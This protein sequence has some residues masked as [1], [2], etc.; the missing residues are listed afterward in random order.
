MKGDIE[1]KTKVITI[2]LLFSV[3]ITITIYK[4][5]NLGG[6]KEKPSPYIS[7]EQEKNASFSF[8][9]MAD[10]RGTDGG[11]NKEAII[12]TMESI[13]KMNPQ[14]IFAVM[15]GDLVEGSANY[16]TIKA[17]LINFKST[18]TQYYPINFFYPGFGNHEAV[19][20]QN[21]EQAFEEVF[22]EIKANFL[23]GYHNTVYYFDKNNSR[24]YMLNSNHP[25]QEHIISDEQLSWIKSNND[26]V[27]KHNFYFFHEP[28]Y[29]TGAHIGSSLDV[30]KVQRDKL[31]E[32]IDYSQGPMVFCGHEHNYTRRH[33]N[34]EFNETISGHSFKF[35]Q[36][37]YQVTAGTFGSPVYN[38][39]TEKK[40][41]DISPVPEY[42]FSVVNVNENKVRVSV[43]NLKG[44]IIDEFEQ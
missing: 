13:K 17:Q 11:I 28:A 31:W 42:N 41:V 44:K 34:S 33:I 43:Y 27:K 30:N 32:I 8:V 16:E 25:G 6:K 9:V 15:P 24:F 19:A 26:G 21:G 1:I 5:G 12:K 10:S 39:Y 36:F 29:P 2:I 18:V 37:V 23:D 35:N 3:L 20:G 40:N 7:T 14:P 4:F 22:S 38:G